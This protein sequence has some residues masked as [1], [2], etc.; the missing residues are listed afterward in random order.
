[1]ALPP[2]TVVIPNSPVAHSIPIKKKRLLS[3][4]EKHKS[5]LGLVVSELHDE[6]V[7][8][9]RQSDVALSSVKRT[10]VPAPKKMTPKR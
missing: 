10:D 6:G 1:M 2:D 8:I 3:V 5:I 9:V 4:G 7:D